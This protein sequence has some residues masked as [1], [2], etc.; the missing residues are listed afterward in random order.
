MCALFYRPVLAGERGNAVRCGGMSLQSWV[1]TGCFV[2]AGVFS[3]LL[4]GGSEPPT[5][6][7][8]EHQPL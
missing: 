7:R 8:R 3:P 4:V 5:D 6:E 1:S 2:L